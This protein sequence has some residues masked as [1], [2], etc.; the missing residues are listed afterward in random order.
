MRDLCGGYSGIVL[1]SFT[2]LGREPFADPSQ[3]PTKHFFTTVGSYNQQLLYTLQAQ[4]CG[5]KSTSHLLWEQVPALYVHYTETAGSLRSE[6]ELK[7]V[8]AAAARTFHLA[9][10]SLASSRL[11]V[12][13]LDLYNSFDMQRCSLPS[14][15]L[16]QLEARY[17][18]LSTSFASTTSLSMSLCN[19]TGPESG[20]TTTFQLSSVLGTAAY[21]YFHVPDHRDHVSLVPLLHMMRNLKHFDLHFFGRLQK[22]SFEDT[23]FSMS[24][25]RTSERNT[26]PK[27]ESCRIRGLCVDLDS[28]L[29]FLEQTKPRRLALEHCA[30]MRDQWR[31]V[32]D[33]ITSPQA[34]FE[35]LHLEDLFEKFRHLWFDEPGRGAYG[36][37]NHVYGCSAVERQGESVV[38]PIGYFFLDRNQV[39]DPNTEYH[40]WL[41]RHRL[42]YMERY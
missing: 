26:L 36:H 10:E 29:P 18:D 32:F 6:A 41:Q 24:L 28:L 23:F 2:L 7:L 30:A 13:K 11:T 9:M 34:G 39:G 42:E 21:M 8:R 40:R 5:S 38:L 12:Q 1:I 16:D 19:P 15:E 27:L 25:L 22:P 3:V 35:S 17:P 37:T 31:P 33:Y 20:Y 4:I 14:I